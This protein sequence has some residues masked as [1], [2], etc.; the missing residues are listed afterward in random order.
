MK[1]SKIRILSLSIEHLKNVQYG[2]FDF[3]QD[4]LPAKAFDQSS[5]IGFY[6]QN[7]SGK[8][9]V[10]Q[11][12]GLFKQIAM[13]QPLWTD[14]E[15]CINLDSN[16][17]TISI[18]F[19]IKF[20]DGKSYHVL[21]SGT[22]AKRATYKVGC[23]FAAEKLSV[24]SEVAGK[25]PG[26]MTNLFSYELNF[27]DKP[28]FTPK[29]R[30]DSIVKGQEKKIQASV[31][32]RISQEK[33]TSLLFSPDFFALL[34]DSEETEMIEIV[35]AINSYANFNLFTITGVHSGL[36][37]MDAVI[38]LSVKYRHK[39]AT[40]IGDIPIGQQGPITVNEQI[41]D[42]TESVLA[43]M[44]D[45]LGALVPGLSIEPMI[46]GREL[47]NDGSMGVR[48]ELVSVRQDKRL[49]IRYESEGVRKILSVLNLIIAMYNNDSFCV[50]IDELDAG[51]FEVLL[52][53]LLKVIME[54][55]KGQLVF[56]S[57][58]LRPL[59]ILDKQNIVFTTTNPE[60]RYI[61]LKNIRPTNN[62]RDCYIRA[63]NIG[64]QDEP[65]ATET[66]FHLIRRALRNSGFKDG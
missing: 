47:M 41:F 42:L 20:D 31:A 33:K 54:S 58:N 4:V 38:P 5:V 26:R 45:V 15:K 12:L 52:G 61:H 13:G 25:I 64:G 48:Y 17:A 57:H 24:A 22:I 19:L 9:T 59:E 30:Y 35:Q 65:L 23:A 14:M 63:L 16:K 10:I 49:P 8:T 66:K 56:T 28:N 11:A 1:N 46:Y 32:M 34:K 44:A 2:S 36:I 27:D 40:A 55:G 51:V 7:G 21:Y 60:N 53:D 43:S 6:G 50:A 62:L 37:S 18:K 29:A 39:D 3:Q